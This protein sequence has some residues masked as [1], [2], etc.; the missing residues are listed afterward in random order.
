VTGS[1]GGL[2]AGNIE[3]LNLTMPAPDLVGRPVSLPPRPVL[4]TGRDDLFATL[5]DRLS[6]ADEPWPRVVALHG[7]GGAGKSS[8]AAEYAH[9]R[10]ADVGVAWQFP[11]GDRTL[12]QAEF[13]RLG[14]LI[15]AA[16]GAMD[17]RDPVASVHAVLADSPLD[18]L[19]IFDNAPSPASVLE[20]L[21]PAG[22]G[23]VLITSQHGT[24]PPR[25]GLEV[26][27]LRMNVA[28]TYLVNRTGEAD[29]ATA[30]E[31]AD[32]LGGL[33]LA[34]EQAA[35]YMQATGTSMTGYL[36]L[37]HHRRAD[38]LARGDVSGHPSS[39]ATTLT[40]ALRQLDH[41]AAAAVALLRLLACLAAE[42]APLPL[43]RAGICAQDLG[44][45][46]GAAAV[47]VLCDPVVAGDAVSALR[48]YSLIT[49]AEG[50]KVQVHRIV[51]AVTLDQM[52]PADS[53]EY[54][55]AAAA[56]VAA[57]IPGDVT[58]PDAWPACAALL[59]HAR[60]LLDLTGS[61]LRRIGT[62]LGASGSYLAA[63]DLFEQIADAHNRAAAYGPEH[64]DTLPVRASLA[65]WTGQAGDPAAA[66]DQ[67]A[68]L[69]PVMVEIL[70]AEHPDT[71]TARASLASFTGQAGDPAAA[72]D[73][74]AALLPVREKVSGADH[75]ETLTARANLA[76]FTGQA[77]DPAAARDQ[78]AALLPLREK[79]LG[80]EHPD[81]LTA[82]ANL[83]RWTGH[84]GDPA[85]ARDQ[86]AA[87]LPVR[88]KVSGAEHPDTLT[89]RIN[90]A[91]W[92]G[93]AGDPAAARDQYAALLP[94]IERILGAEHP[95]TLTD[96]A[97]LATFTG[98]AGDPAAARDQYAALLPV[99]EKV[100]GADHPE[101]LTARANLAYWRRQGEANS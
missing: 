42:P 2:A 90:L 77:G 52:T 45:G 8:L 9:R 93:H 41:E 46:A 3:N 11:A 14:A 78:Y 82:R 67:Y 64:P 75:P 30:A 54:Q 48:R 7:M 76:S 20:F 68:A 18:W 25:Q 38:L 98:Q 79:I 55:V 31:L 73:R 83:A 70:G 13:A 26:P 10:Q 5:A 53:A 40:L 99:R 69:L 44:G 4:L 24:W 84:A 36:D 28:A 80:A 81:T 62:Y 49:L 92:T 97:T 74:Y 23:Q 6:G 85:A 29:Y 1:A 27:P 34:L 58:Q 59:P 15:G 65:F 91:R 56:A 47:A 19:L 39:A 37:Y 32:E 94:V 16:A 17:P 89:D 100:S 95:D 57:A 101:T 72:R 21:P 88:E 96:R 22:H 71:L 61:D 35:A 12:M 60:A 86:C 66:R 51:Q 33:P 43:L 87:L 50:G 63:R